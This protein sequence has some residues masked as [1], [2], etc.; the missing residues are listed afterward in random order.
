LLADEP[1]GNLDTQT[2]EEIMQITRELHEQQRLTI[3]L[4]THDPAVASYA[5][6]VVALRDGEIIADQPTP[7]CGGPPIPNVRALSMAG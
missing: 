7:R 6:R 5:E 2:S 4:V 3:V 1:T